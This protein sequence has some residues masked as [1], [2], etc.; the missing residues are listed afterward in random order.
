MACDTT[1]RGAS[2]RAVV[3]I[4]HEAVTAAVDQVRSLATH[5]FGHQT[6]AAAGDVQHGRVELDK[7]H[8]A[9]LD[10]RAIRHRVTV[11]GGHDGIGGFAIDLPGAARTEDRLFGPNERLAV[12]RIPRQ[13]SA[14][15]PSCTKK[16]DR[17]RVLPHLQMFGTPSF[18]ND[19]A[20]DLRAGC[21]S[22][23][24]QDAVVLVAALATQQTGHPS[25]RN[26][27]PSRSALQSV[28]EP[29][30]HVSHD[31]LIAHRSPPATSVSS[32][33]ESKLSSGDITPAMPP[34]A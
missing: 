9:Q 17:E 26:W 5:R 7:F 10:P 14:A 13:R 16:I 19:G 4:R 8:I 34:C 33:C 11:T 29:P 25:C 2:S 24:V 23:R 15:L 1:S 6:A 28:P 27:F 12:I 22:H 20:H 30:G 3:V 21:I 32:M 18:G 31:C